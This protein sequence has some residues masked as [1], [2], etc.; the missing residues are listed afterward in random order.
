MDPNISAEGNESA[1]SNPMAGAR[2]SP[3]RMSWFLMKNDSLYAP[4]YGTY[5]LIHGMDLIDPDYANV[6]VD[7]IVSYY[8]DG[9]TVIGKLLAVA[10]N[11]KLMRRSTDYWLKEDRKKT[12]LFKSFIVVEYRVA[13]HCLVLK[14]MHEEDAVPLSSTQYPCVGEM[15]IFVR[16]GERFY[17]G[18]I[19]TRSN[20]IGDLVNEVTMVN[21][22]VVQK[23]RSTFAQP[24]SERNEAVTSIF[25]YAINTYIYCLQIDLDLDAATIPIGNPWVLLQYSNNI[26]DCVYTVV[27][28]NDTEKWGCNAYPGIQTF[29]HINNKIF[30]A[31][32]IHKSHD[33]DEMTRALNTIMYSFVVSIYPH[34][35]DIEYRNI[36]I[37][38]VCGNLE[39]ECFEEVHIRISKSLLRAKFN[40]MKLELAR[41]EKGR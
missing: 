39:W 30:Q 33:R 4:I 24:V 8:I 26:Y 28:Y 2:P 9:A 11:L 40:N 25:I 7:D 5:R 38:K 19:L 13:P 16:D 22:N 35:N 18:R 21:E 10:E 41:W 37:E 27:R 36:E 1:Q 15:D 12:P 20:K 6:F 14:V 3:C 17:Q 32:I 23:I 29:I 31:L 34:S